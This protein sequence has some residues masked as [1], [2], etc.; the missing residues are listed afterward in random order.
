MFYTIYTILINICSFFFIF[1]GIYILTLKKATVFLWNKPVNNITK[2]FKQYNRCVAFLYV[3]LGL[4][5]SVD[6][7]IFMYV[8]TRLASICLVLI[9]AAVIPTFV[10]IQ[11]FIASRYLDS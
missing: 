10:S 7:L 4:F 11:T 2:K 8:N 5:F 6:N 9:I 1:Y 3:L